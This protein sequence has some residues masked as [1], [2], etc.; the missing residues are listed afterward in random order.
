MTVDL[1]NLLYSCM[2]SQS[3]YGLHIYFWL[4][5]LHLALNY[6]D[7][8]HW[9]EDRCDTRCSGFLLRQ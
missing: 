7:F 6:N 9:G 2:Q 8:Q 3:E 1:Y 4:Y 5:F